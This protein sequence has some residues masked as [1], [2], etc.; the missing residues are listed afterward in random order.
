M[1][2][3][4]SWL[5]DLVQLN[6][7][8]EI[9]AEGL[10]MAG[11]EI[12]AIEDLASHAQGVVVGLVKDHQ[13]HPNAD[14]LSVCQVDVG[15]GECLQI[16][17]GA[18]NVRTG[19]HV[20]VAM[21][22]ATLPAVGI[23]IKASQLRGVPSQGMICS[24]AELGLESNC[25]GI[26]ILEEIAENVPNLGQ[27][28]GPLFGLD[29]TVLELAI[30]ANRPDGMSMVGI[31]REVAALTGASL[32]LPQLDMA[33]IHKSFTPDSTSSVS[34]LKGGLYG[35][36][37]LEN[38]DG[39]LTSPAWIKQRL[40]RSGL[41]S[42]N[43]VVDITNLV[44]LEQGQPLHAFD[45][46]ALEMITG[47]TVSAECFGLRQ[48]RN[49]EVFN[50]L[51]G[52]QLALNE[53]CQIVTCHHIP[54]A[55]AGVM[56]SAESGV[57]AKTRRI[58][59]ESAMFTP[60]AVRTTCRA[61]GLRTDASSRFEKG[62]PIEMTL[63]SARRAVT[64]MEEHLGIKSNGC[65]VYGELLKTAEPVKLRRNAIHRL[66]GPVAE[67]VSNEF[68]L[69]SLEGDLLSSKA[70]ENDHRYLEDEIIE[71]SLLALG[72]ELAPC[73]DGWLVTV[74]P[75]R[76]RDL[77]R[78]VDLIEEV[79]RLV[80]FDRFE[81][82]LPDPIEPG[83]LTNTQ[84]AER[85]LR[86]M[87]SGA[88]L[89]EVTTL[90]LVGADN[91]EPQRI[92][93]SNPL[94]AETSHLRTNL[95]EEHLRICQ[96]NLQSSQ[97]GCWLYEIGNV[98]T[99]TGEQI[100]QRAVLGGVICAERRFE[101]W[102]TNGKIKSMTYHQ[103]RGQLAQVFKGLKLDIND[104]PLK[105]NPSLH[106][107]R[108]AELFVEGKLLGHFGQLHPALS[109]RLDLPEATYLF[110]L[111]L[112]YIIQAATRSNRW[113]PIF[114]PFP[115]VPAMELDLAVI[116]S[117]EC[118]CSDLMQAIRKAGKPLLEHVELIDR[119]EGGQLDHDSCSQAFRLRYRSK[120]STLSEDRVNPIHEKVRQALVKQFSAE[121][122]S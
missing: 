2:V 95:W 111:D 80:G 79:S 1:R 121:L 19:I 71:R 67:E 87:L 108:S 54:V 74:P 59:L 83:G 75:T 17:C 29:D 58:W 101:R 5:Q 41:K 18:Q 78:E 60:T 93:I 6:E 50:G 100:N 102:S 98:Y 88:G 48:A 112:Q 119:F 38:V 65:W 81:A 61:L 109:E 104:L 35:L 44:M 115:T 31:A 22:G 110:A 96:R 72:C 77:S 40:E 114:R 107:G 21:V 73:E 26:A 117:R 63:A 8:V 118:S 56:G 116:V 13:P 84:T 70:D 122:R 33:P 27:P 16:V 3:P 85:L 36:T 120:D 45:I 4:L 113:T 23:K 82:H 66:L 68:L 86:Q 37:A 10:S 55:I 28:V 91:D 89:Q 47:Q 103:A 42:V 69:S 7:T 64:L 106:P 20:P 99:Q 24:L 49:N 14:K 92:A 32:Q 52:H 30:T 46:D 25:D 105:D 97:P 62:L 11:F 94:L 15:S 43:G 57:S 39:G 9:L 53:N 34:M 90:S 51:D 76:R 12:E